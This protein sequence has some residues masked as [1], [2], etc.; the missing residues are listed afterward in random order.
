MNICVLFDSVMPFLGVYP[1]DL[2]T[3]VPGDVHRSVRTIAV[4]N[5]FKLEAAQMLAITT[6]IVT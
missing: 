4:C 6:L 1:R 2:G 3:C 5:R